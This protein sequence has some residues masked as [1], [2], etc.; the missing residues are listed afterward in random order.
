MYSKSF[1]ISGVEYKYNLRWYDMK[2][3]RRVLPVML[4]LAMFVGLMGSIAQAEPSTSFAIG[5]PY[6]LHK[7]MTVYSTSYDARAGKNGVTTYNA[8]SYFVYRMF[9]GMLN[10]ARTKNAPGGWIDPKGNVAPPVVKPLPPV[11]KPTP[12]VTKPTPPV[13]A[14]DTIVASERVNVRKG[15]SMTFDTVRS[16]P[17]GTKAVMIGLEGMWAKIT[18]NNETLYSHINYWVIPDA[19]LAKFK[20]PTVPSKPEPVHEDTVVTTAR[21]NVR[22]GATVS[23]KVV[24]TLDKGSNAIMEGLDGKWLKVRYAGGTGYSHVDYWSVP[25]KVMAKFL[26]KPMPKPEPIPIPKHEDTIVTTASVNLRDGASVNST[27]LRTLTKGSE[28]V[29]IGIDGKWLNVDYNGTK[30]YSHVNYWDV[31]D[32]VMSKFLPKPTPKPEPK[33][34]PKPEPKPEPKPTPKSYVV[35]LDPGHNNVGGGAVSVFDGKQ[36]DETTI[37]YQVATMTKS[38]LEDRGY[39][40]HISKSS[41]GESVSLADRTNIANKLGA[42]IFVSIHTNAFT[43]P[44]AHGTIGFYGGQKNNPFD[45]NWQVRSQLLASALSESVGTLFRSQKIVKDTD[46]GI[47]YAVNRLSNMPST[48]LELGFITNREDVVVLDSNDGQYNMA[49]QIANGVDRYFSN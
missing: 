45:S 36:I 38:I 46:Y 29:M 30:G 1:I 8:G 22:E 4:L 26:P 19:T 6:V 18:L 42:D 32:K 9:D 27:R 2:V 48:L 49:V 13:E 21:V 37:N 12:P 43:N 33:P 14:Q 47:S 16:V 5:D 3:L 23:S 39:T 25:D 40:V 35:F 31:P 44:N 7:D 41:L 15:P 28:A 20:I 10:I 24:S 11:V 17:V 34:T